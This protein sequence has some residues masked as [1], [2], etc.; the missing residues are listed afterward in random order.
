MRLRAS[1]SYR[2]M[3]WWGGDECYCVP[4]PGE[5][6]GHHPRILRARPVRD[7]GPAH[8]VVDCARGRPGGRH[9][10]RACRARTVT[11][12][13]RSRFS[14]AAHRLDAVR[15]VLVALSGRCDGSAVGSDGL[16]WHLR[17][18]AD[19]F[20]HP[21]RTYRSPEARTRWSSAGAALARAATR[22]AGVSELRVAFR[23]TRRPREPRSV[24]AVRSVLERG[25]RAA[26][27]GVRARDARGLRVAH[28][29]TARRIRARRGERAAGLLP[30]R[31]RG[32]PRG[33]RL[34]R[35]PGCFTRRT[36]RG[37]R[38][39]RAIARRDRGGGTPSGRRGTATTATS[40]R[41]VRAGATRRDGS[42]CSCNSW[43]T[44]PTT[45]ARARCPRPP[46]STS[47]RS[48][49]CRIATRRST[50]GHRSGWAH[51]DARSSGRVQTRPPR[52]GSS[53]A[54]RRR[55]E[56]PV[57]SRRG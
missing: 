2:S 19:G 14:P 36:D 46:V 55:M 4:P 41:E 45:R 18:R 28:A 27:D 29:R 25:A 52:G 37:P 9:D 1:T 54:S 51:R 21:A 16:S 20:F 34:R 5:S 6:S 42:T 57:A 17:C 8:V 15:D 39:G 3:T 32:V 13:L 43:S 11:A 26:P 44:S 47:T 22:E 12:T 56:C 48:R 31:E 7:A 50:R 40:T 33:P 38:D 24:D 10:A 30:R 35:S 23:G 49:A 53:R